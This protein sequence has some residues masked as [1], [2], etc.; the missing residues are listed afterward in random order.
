[1]D[2]VLPLNAMW[3]LAGCITLWALLPHQENWEGDNRYK[4][5]L[6]DKQLSRAEPLRVPLTGAGE[7]MP[8]ASV[9]TLAM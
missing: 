5:R 1:M 8:R 7:A 3:H 2:L 6:I 4:E 9:S